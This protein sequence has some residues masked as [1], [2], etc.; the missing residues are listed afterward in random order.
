[1]RVCMWNRV[2]EPLT[3]SVSGVTWHG[4]VYNFL[5]TKI[6]TWNSNSHTPSDWDE[7]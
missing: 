4:L 6:V 7:G 5:S 1:M 3:L 2:M